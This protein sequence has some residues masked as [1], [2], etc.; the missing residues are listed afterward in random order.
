VV[1]DHGVLTAKADGSFV[2]TAK[3]PSA[4]KRAQSMLHII[5]ENQ[6]GQALAAVSMRCE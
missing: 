4:T 1:R 6:A 3:I 2:G 5:A